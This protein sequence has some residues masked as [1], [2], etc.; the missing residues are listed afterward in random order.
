MLMTLHFTCWRSGNNQCVGSSALVV[1][2]WLWP[3]NRTFLEVA[4]MVVTRWILA[5]LHSVV[6]WWYMYNRVQKLISKSQ[7]NVRTLLLWSEKHREAIFFLIS[8]HD[9]WLLHLI[10]FWTPQN[11]ASHAYHELTITRY[12]TSGD[13]EAWNMPYSV[14]FMQ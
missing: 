13:R 11:S 14:L 6:S 3:G 2:R 12:E 10:R 1:S 5:C 7:C 8:S 4:S 9:W